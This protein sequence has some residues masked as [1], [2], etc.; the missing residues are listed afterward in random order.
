MPLRAAEVKGM[1]SQIGTALLWGAD[2]SR[3]RPVCRSGKV[4]DC[5]SNL[6]LGHP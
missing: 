4:L 1:G 3:L 5:M 2:E 6:R